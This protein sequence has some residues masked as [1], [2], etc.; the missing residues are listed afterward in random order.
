[1][2]GRA[3]PDQIPSGVG[4][5]DGSSLQGAETEKDRKRRQNRE[6]RILARSYSY[7]YH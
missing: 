4:A 3:N 2:A 5:P 6:V 1:M 7:Q